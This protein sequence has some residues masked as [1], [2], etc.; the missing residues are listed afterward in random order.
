MTGRAIR[1]TL[2]TAFVAAVSLA[3][4]PA[5]GA[6]TSVFG[7]AIPCTPQ[8]ADGNVRFCQGSNPGIATF[9]NATRIDVNVA[10]PPDPTPLAD[11]PYPMVMI[12]HGWG[13]S[14]LGLSTM[15]EWAQ[16]GYAVF[17]M[18][19]RGW[20]NSCGAM[21]PDR[22]PPGNPACAQGYN[23][24]MDTRYEVRD[25]QY[26][27][28]LLVD[29]G[30]AQPTKLGATG[31]SY[32]GGLSMSLAALKN[33]VM[34]PDDSLVPWTSPNGTPMAMAAAQPDIPWSDLAY[35][36]TPNGHTLDYVA[37]APY[38]QRGRVGVLKQSFVAGLFGVGLASSNYAL[39][40][41]DPDSAVPEWYALLNSGEPYDQNPEALDIVDEVTTHHSSY[42]IDHSQP[43]APLL[44]SNGWTDDLF[45]P[46]EAI[47]FYNRTRTEY[48]GAK[49]SLFFSDAGHQRGQNKPADTAARNIRTHEWFDFY[50]KGENSEPP[51]GVEVLTQTCPG[52]PTPA[53]SGGPFT[54]T[55]WKAL[56]PGEVRLTE[57]ASQTV[58]PGGGNPGAGQAYDPI[59]GDG[60]CATFSGA[61]APGAA[62][63]RLPAAPTGA[64]RWPARRRSS[65]TS[66]RSGRRRSWRPGSSTSTR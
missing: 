60:A 6:V 50:L 24:L 5:A 49:V 28:G 32:G 40:G 48:P 9:D 52:P 43:P 62:N 19:D 55:T 51:A 16:D 7:G 47:R 63:Y 41:T 57:A 45:P 37:D 56:A 61:D 34:M 64:T 26:L 22:L 29:E 8:P 66:T 23:H 38:F 44:I 35:S 46:D 15:K 10:L 25:A 58:T 42:Y 18:S 12:F 65:P 36:L 4:A 54:A 30:V 27:A 31:G 39:P 33:R 21:D 3:A 59:A 13:G 2:A 20:G 14:K 1:G 53:P 17:S 11:G